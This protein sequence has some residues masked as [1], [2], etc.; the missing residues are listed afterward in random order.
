MPLSKSNA[1][2]KILSYGDVVLRRSDLDILRGPYDINDRLIEFFFAYL[3]PPDPV[4]LFSPS[5]SFW[6]SNCPDPVSLSEAAGPLKLHLR[7]LVLFTINNNSDVT[8]AEGGTHWSLLVYY[9]GTNKFVHHDSSRG[10]NRW[11]AESLFEAVKGFIGD[12]GEA[13]YVEG[14]A[15]QQSHGYDCGLYVMAIARVVCDWFREAE[16]KD[17]GESWF[18]ALKE[19]VDAAVVAELRGELLRLILGLMETK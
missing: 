9:R 16:V 18:S 12:G 17:E 15:P 1:D 13:R 11:H 4:L 5:V 10:M 6:L 2:E 19:E 3:S 14:F 7:D 8:A